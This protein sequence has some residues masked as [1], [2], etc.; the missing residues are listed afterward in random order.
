LGVAYASWTPLISAASKDISYLNAWTAKQP[1]AYRA[2]LN[3]PGTISLKQELSNYEAAWK[4]AKTAA[5]KH[6]AWVNLWKWVGTYSTGN[7]GMALGLN[8]QVYVD[9]HEPSLEAKMRIWE[10]ELNNT[11]SAKTAAQLSADMANA[12]VQA[13]YEIPLNVEQTVYLAKPNVSG[14]QPNPWS[15]GNFYQFQYLELK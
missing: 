7:A 14:V 4:T 8:G 5:A 15:W 13:A 10:A 11:A 2:A 12:M 3:P 1:A 9:Q 6:A